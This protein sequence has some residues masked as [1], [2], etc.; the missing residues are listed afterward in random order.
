MRNFLI[1]ISLF[2]L[3]SVAS[4][5]SYSQWFEST[6]SAYIKDGDKQS[7][8]TQAMQ[9]ALKKA[10]LVAGAS[11]SSVQQVVN[12]LLTQDNI[13][14]RAS[15]IINSLELIDEVYEDNVIH[16]TVRADIFP[17]QQQC[18][19]ADY[20][21]ALLLTKSNLLHREQANIGKI[22]GID[23]LLIEKLANKINKAS[24]YIDTRLALKNKTEF[25]L[26]NQSLNNEALKNTTISLAS[27]TDSQ[28][29]LYSEIPDVSFDD[30]V[31]NTW[32]FW[33]A[34]QFK[35]NISFNIFV[36]DGSNGELIYQNKY[37]D[38]APWTYKKRES[39]DINSASFW[40]SEYGVAVDQLLEKAVTDLDEN[41]MCKPTQGKILH[42]IGDTIT[43]NLG[44][45]QGVK[46]GDEF[47]LLHVQNFVSDK[48]ITYAGYNV[49][50]YKVQVSSVT[51]YTAIAKTID[52]R[53]LGN[54]QRNDI[55]VRK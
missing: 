13:S 34:D 26:Y 2:C 39:V 55:A 43:I 35:R 44:A 30:E 38:I 47:S 36:Y 21:K 22:Y 24:Q 45:K 9:H 14:I 5:P 6:G 41:I 28:F 46:I 48:G 32:Q 16:V 52:N 23:K 4:T 33:Q 25:S 17:Q 11:V 49:S 27:A 53:L 50:P 51:E 15:G 40:R 12:G 31:Q 42:V 19:S 8:R 20:K 10:L 54:I 29:I 1:L 7:A 18:F 37:T 3:L